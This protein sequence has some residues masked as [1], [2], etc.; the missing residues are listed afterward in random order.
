M[1]RLPTERGAVWPLLMKG[2]PRLPLAAQ[3][4]TVQVGTAWQR[5]AGRGRDP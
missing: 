5:G 2:P 4:G 1:K 3:E